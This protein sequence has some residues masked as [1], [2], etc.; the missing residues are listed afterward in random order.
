MNI[1]NFPLC[2]YRFNYEILGTPK[3][4]FKHF[5]QKHNLLSYM[6]ILKLCRTCFHHLNEYGIITY[7][8]LMH[9]VTHGRVGW[10]AWLPCKVKFNRYIYIR[11][12]KKLYFRGNE[13]FFWNCL[14]LLYLSMLVLRSWPSSIPG[15]QHPHIF[16][17]GHI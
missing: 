2:K 8:M 13:A 14:F 11:G 16:F 6:Q 3:N 15:T 5:G 10:V 4:T 17:R 1:A 9:L 12:A 7:K